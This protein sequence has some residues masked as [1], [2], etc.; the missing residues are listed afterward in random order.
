M[1]QIAKHKYVPF[2]VCQLYP[3]KPVKNHFRKIEKETEY[4]AKIFSVL[5]INVLH[6]IHIY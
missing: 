4:Y 1:Y 3:N 2:I 5:C 6:F